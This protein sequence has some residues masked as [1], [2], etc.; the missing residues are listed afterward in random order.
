[1][2]IRRIYAYTMNG[3][4]AIVK[5][6]RFGISVKPIEKG[7]GTESP[8]RFNLVSKT[9]CLMLNRSSS[10]PQGS[11]HL[12]NERNDMTVQELTDKLGAY[13]P[14][15][16]VYFREPYDEGDTLKINSVWESETIPEGEEEAEVIV[17]LVN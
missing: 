7:C 6:Y 17:V 16:Q 3:I 9:L 5:E 11:I 14:Q 15:M 8:S 2:A 1:M 12:S 10:L 13:A 4:L